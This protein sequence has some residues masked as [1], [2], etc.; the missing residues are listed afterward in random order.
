[1]PL[2]P[3]LPLEEGGRRG[4]DKWK[5][6]ALLDDRAGDDSGDNTSPL[7]TEGKYE[8]AGLGDKE[9]RDGSAGERGERTERTDDR[10]SADE[11]GRRGGSG[12]E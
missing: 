6:G 8:A 4:D 10:S 5:D 12:R 1:M 9:E 7:L 3:T 2:L 11:E